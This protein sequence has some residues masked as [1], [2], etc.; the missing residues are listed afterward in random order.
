[1]F[2]FLFNSVRL[3]LDR[4]LIKL[5]RQTILK[6][7]KYLFKTPI[8]KKIYLYYECRIHIPA[9]IVFCIYIAMQSYNKIK[10]NN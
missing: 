8:H 6:L 5:K 9:N 1:M 10:N 4:N 2:I 3:F 7:Q